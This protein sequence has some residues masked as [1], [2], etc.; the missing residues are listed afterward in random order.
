[1]RPSFSSSETRKI[2]LMAGLFS[3]ML[4]CW[5]AM[6]ESVINPDGICYVLSAGAFGQSGIGAAMHL[7]AQA[8]WPF[9]SALIY[10]FSKIS[11]LILKHSKRY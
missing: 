6:R 8:M 9:Y 4:S 1:M 3:I 11:F 10:T 2:Y 7:C 5:I